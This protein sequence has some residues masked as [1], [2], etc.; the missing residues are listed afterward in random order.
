M[1]KVLKQ[2]GVKTISTKNELKIFGK[3]MIDAKN[4]KLLYP[5]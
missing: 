3:G 4:K 1:Q 2:I 5:I